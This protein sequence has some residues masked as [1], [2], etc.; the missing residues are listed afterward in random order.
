MPPKKALRVEGSPSTSTMVITGLGVGHVG[1]VITAISRAE[2]QAKAEDFWPVWLVNA[3]E[4]RDAL[5]AAGY[6]A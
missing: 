6:T 2:G 5:M 3:I 4:V 1:G